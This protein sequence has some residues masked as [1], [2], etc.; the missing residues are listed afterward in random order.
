MLAREGAWE[1]RSVASKLQRHRTTVPLLRFARRSDDAIL[2]GV[3]SGVGA[4]FGVEP[5]VVRIAFV[6]LSF[7]GGVGIFAYL[8]AWALSLEPG[9][10]ARAAPREPSVQQATAFG[11]I[12]LGTTLVLRSAGLWF[13]DAVGVPLLVVA[14]GAGVI[15]ARTDDARRPRFGRGGP[16]PE[17][18]LAPPSLTR[19]LFGGGLVV[20]GV[21]VFLVANESFSGVLTVVAAVGATAL[22]LVVVFGPWV[23]RLVNSLGAERRDRIRSEERAEV[24]AHLHDSVLQTLALIQRSATDPRKTVSLARRQEREL[25]DWL[26]GP[27]TSDPGRLDVAVR[28]VAADVEEAHDV[29]VEVVVVGDCDVDERVAA[30]VA[31][32]REA[33]TNAAKHSGADDISMYVECEPSEVVAYVRDR[34]KGFDPHAVPDDRRGIAHSIVGRVERQGGEVEIAS[35]PGEGC[36]VRIRVPGPA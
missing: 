5:T 11:C 26:Y 13:G 34:G 22:G 20:G 19:V 33:A 25:R 3:A 6:V 7:A 8:A 29:K 16:A 14:V 4:R 23:W 30:L 10:Q 24:A 28:A 9:D 2:A 35:A 36:E 17:L 27:K 31:A 21:A 18:P 32:C 15:Y 1:H 12:V